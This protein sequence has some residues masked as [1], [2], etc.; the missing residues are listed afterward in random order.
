M[1]KPRDGS[2]PQTVEVALTR[3]PQNLLV[4]EYLLSRHHDVAYFK[5]LA[6]G[7]AVLR[8]VRR[9]ASD[10]NTKAESVTPQK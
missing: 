7:D 4:G 6:S 9:R 5:R 8:I 2:Q 10:D 1:S 3:R